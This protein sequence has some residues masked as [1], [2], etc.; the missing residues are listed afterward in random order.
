MPVLFKHLGHTARFSSVLPVFSRT[1]LRHSRVF[2]FGPGHL[3]EDAGAE[4]HVPHDPKQ[5]VGSSFGLLLQRQSVGDVQ[6]MP[7][8]K[9]HVMERMETGP[10]ACAFN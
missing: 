9:Q 7:D 4:P 1:C 10:G 6:K 8:A 3:E 2:F 5:G